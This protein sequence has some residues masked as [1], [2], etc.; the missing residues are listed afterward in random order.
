MMEKV[1]IFAGGALIGSMATYF[2]LKKRI[3]KKYDDISKKEIDSMRRMYERKEEKLKS[4]IHEDLKNDISDTILGSKGF[5]KDDSQV[6]EPVK[7]EDKVPQNYGKLVRQ[8]NKPDR[9]SIDILPDNEDFVNNNK[10]DKIS[11]E[12]F[13]EDEVLIEDGEL[14]D[15]ASTI[16]YQAL[17]HFGECGEEDVVYVRNE[18]L[19]TIFEVIQEHGSWYEEE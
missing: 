6:D 2:A 1:V 12:Y 13:A 10:Y 16:G 8:Y 18:K 5:A 4:E 7:N 17:D 11:L 14:C 19:N 3:E 9:N 15:I